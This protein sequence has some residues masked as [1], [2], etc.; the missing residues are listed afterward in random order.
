VPDPIFDRLQ[1][2]APNPM[3]L[4]R[5]EDEILP[6]IRA[7]HVGVRDHSSMAYVVNTARGAVIMS[8]CCFKYEN[9]EQPQPTGLAESLEDCLTAYA[10]IR[11]E[12]EI[13]MPLYD[14][15]LLERFPNGRIA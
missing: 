6:G 3:R 10:R 7:F 14:P 2:G 13:V 11:N 8:D 5:D 4:L 15:A 9:I 1:H 12:A